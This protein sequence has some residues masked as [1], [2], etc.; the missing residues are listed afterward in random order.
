VCLRRR[1]ETADQLRF[2]AG[3]AGDDGYEPP[4]SRLADWLD[5]LSGGGGDRGSDRAAQ[6]AVAAEA[7]GGDVG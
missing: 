3:M 1:L 7:L 2:L 6:I 5:G 4:F